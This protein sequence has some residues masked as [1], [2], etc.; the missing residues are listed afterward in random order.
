MTG[1]LLAAR[2]GASVYHATWEELAEL[3]PR[4]EDGTACDLLATDTPYSD[5]THAGHDEGAEAATADVE[6]PEIRGAV[7]RQALGLRAIRRHLN[8]AAWSAADVQAFVS[9]WSPLTRGW[10]V[11]ITDHV[12]APAWAAAMEAQG[13]YV[14]APLP[15]VAVGSRVRLTGDGP[16]CW[17][18]QIVVGRPR[19]EPYSKW[20]TLPG[21]Y[22]LPPG[23]GERWIVVGGKPVWLMER[24]AEDYSRHG[25][26]VC[27]P[28]CG[29]G[30][31]L[32][33]A[34]QT[35]RAAIGGDALR[36]HAD[37]SAERISRMV[38]MPMFAAGG[39]R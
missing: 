18:T 9:A 20:G 31:T 36:E 3:A 2:N 39:G 27:D 35:G 7:E 38:Q 26:I 15:Y 13:R 34:Q 1:T 24:L 17:T 37:M 10:M 21:A 22:I 30:T 8:Y 11:S 12:L 33:A 14:F 5:R 4:R 16:S 23:Y 29:G 28:C 6:R 32:V 19:S 25:E